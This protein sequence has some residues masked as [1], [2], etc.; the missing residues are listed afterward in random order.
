MKGLCCDQFP[1]AQT[2]IY[3]NTNFEGDVMQ[4]LNGIVIGGTGL[5]INTFNDY[6]NGVIMYNTGEPIVKENTFTKCL[7]AVEAV[8]CG[9]ALA[10]GTGNANFNENNFNNCIFGIYCRESQGTPKIVLNK[11]NINQQYN[12]DDYGLEAIRVENIMQDAFPIVK[13]N[14]I[15]NMAI[16]IHL[17][18]AIEAQVRWNHYTTQITNAD[19]AV[20]NLPN[21]GVWIE[22]CTNSSIIEN[23][24]ERLGTDVS[25]DAQ[26]DLMQ[27]INM[28]IST[29]CVLHLNNTTN[30][31]TDINVIANC[32]PA[33]I[34]CNNMTSS[35]RGINFV[36]ATITAFSWYPTD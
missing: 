35:N 20:L 24:I 21:I 28:D 3:T 22:N 12:I 36:A 5:E 25:D 33:T 7:Q 4:K 18:N 26:Q 17:R 32:D 9:Y 29:N 6:Q 2:A 31:G 13:E 11:F 8:S 14:E 23:T 15:N 34:S 27:G 16:G 19:I 10:L 30:M 1:K